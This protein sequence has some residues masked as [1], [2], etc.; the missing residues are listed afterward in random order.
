MK[1]TT[2]HVNAMVTCLLLFGLAVLFIWKGEVEAAIGLSGTIGVVAVHFAKSS[3][4]YSR[5]NDDEECE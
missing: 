1:V 3:N 5:R 4:G 2:I